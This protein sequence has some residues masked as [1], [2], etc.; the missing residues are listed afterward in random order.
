MGQGDRGA[1]DQ[2]QVN[3]LFSIA[4]D[5]NLYHHQQVATN[6]EWGGETYFNNGF[7]KAISAIQGPDNLIH[8][9]YTDANGFSNR[10]EQN[11]DGTWAPS[12]SIASISTT[13]TPVL[14]P[15]HLGRSRSSLERGT[16]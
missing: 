7:A 1:P 12:K 14:V 16:R 10:K 3:H 11:D 4:D 8:L 9:V 5:N 13:V 6:G 2:N 15:I